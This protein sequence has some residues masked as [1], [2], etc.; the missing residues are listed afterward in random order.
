MSRRGVDRG[1]PLVRAPAILKAQEN[2]QRKNPDPADHH[3]R[4]GPRW[5]PILEVADPSQV[6]HAPKA[7]ERTT[8]E[9]LSTQRVGGAQRERGGERERGRGQQRPERSE[10]RRVGKEWRSRGAPE[11]E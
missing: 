2:R 7:G 3:E 6:N 4:M 10:E 5:S 8:P 9:R 1:L 11:R